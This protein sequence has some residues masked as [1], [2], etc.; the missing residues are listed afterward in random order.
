MDQGTGPHGKA[1]AAALAFL[2][3][4]AFCGSALFAAAAALTGPSAIATAAGRRAVPCAVP[5]AVRPCVIRT[6]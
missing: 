4:L 2:A 6:S 5:S 3:V 1:R